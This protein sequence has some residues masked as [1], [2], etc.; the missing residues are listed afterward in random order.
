LNSATCAIPSACS[1]LR[2]RPEMSKRATVAPVI[3]SSPYFTL[4]AS[5]PVAGSLTLSVAVPTDSMSSARSTNPAGTPAGSAA[6]GRPDEL[7]SEA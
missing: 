1:T 6:A 4:L 3:G 7:G 5:M 2:G